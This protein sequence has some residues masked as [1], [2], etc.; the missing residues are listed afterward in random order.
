MTKP[1]RTAVDPRA[2][3]QAPRLTRI[4]AAAAETGLVPINPEGL[5]KGS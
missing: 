3:W 1:H 5:A 4:D 2:K